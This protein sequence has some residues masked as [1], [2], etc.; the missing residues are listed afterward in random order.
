MPSV[1]LAMPL[2]HERRC[3][4]PEVE[5]QGLPHLVASP[6]SHDRSA[7][8]QRPVQRHVH[9]VS[10]LPLG[11]VTCSVMLYYHETIGVIGPRVTQI[12]YRCP[13]EAARVGYH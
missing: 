8:G 7:S 10:A 2:M 5:R 1:W 4:D 9:G 13:Q 11:C 12:D 3:P 6:N